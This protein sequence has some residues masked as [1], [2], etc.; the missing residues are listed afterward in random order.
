MNEKWFAPDISE[1]EKKLKT[2]AASGLSLRAA[3]SRRGRSGS[4][5]FITPKKSVFSMLGEIISDFALV[6]LLIAAF[7]ALCFGEYNLGIGVLLTL[8]FN[9]AVTAFLYYRS[10]RLFESVEGYFHPSVTVIRGGKAYCIDS[11]S[12]VVGD[13]VLI[14]A[15]DVLS[16]DARLITSDKLKV[17][18]RVDRQTV[19]ECEKHAECRVS[20]VEYDIRNMPNM[21]HAGSVIKEGSARAIVTA[22]GGYTY[23]GAMTGGVLLSAR[24]NSFI[25]KKILLEYLVCLDGCR[26]TI[27]LTLSFV[28]L[29]KSNSIDCI[30]VYSCYCRIL[31]VGNILYG[32]Q[33]IL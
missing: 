7:V 22:V 13:V 4:G 21:V 20:D 23:Y 31:N 24:T 30:Y 33:N 3:R 11:E 15:G 6:L 17:M 26:A 19:T 5:L 2:N 27:Q 12:V 29:S 1:I 25:L 18:V 28:Q 8:G 32:V 10:Q 14:S 16:F 9:I